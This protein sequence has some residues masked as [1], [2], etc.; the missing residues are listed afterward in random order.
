MHE[1]EVVKEAPKLVAGM[2]KPG[3]YREIAKMLPA[4]FEYVISR[5]APIAGQPM[6][7]WHEKS[8]EE[9]MAADEAGRADIE[10]CLP[11]ATRIPETAEIKCYELPGATMARMVHKG[12][13][14]SSGTAYEKLFAWIEENGKTLSGP[15]REEYLNDPREVG[16]Q[17]ILTVIYAP[18][19][20]AP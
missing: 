2:R 10:V 14:E 8:V 20:Q 7:L 1:I 3:H 9:A 18:I 11:I 13:Y 6:F 5:S 17:E 12:P 16:P 19:S 4:L 15:V